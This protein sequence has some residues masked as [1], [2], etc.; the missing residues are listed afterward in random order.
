MDNVLNIITIN[1]KDIKQYEQNSKQHP[2]WHIDQIKKSIQEFG[3]NDLIAITDNFEIIEGHGRFEAIKRLGY[4]KI[5]CFV[6]N[7][8]DD[9]SLKKY[10][11]IHN[12]LTLNTDFDFNILESELNKLSDFNIESYGFIF[13]N[14]DF[15]S[16]YLDIDD[17]K[18]DNITKLDK[19]IC[20]NCKYIADKSAFIVELE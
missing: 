10:R 2:R 20:P 9:N 1:I 13:S 17:I 19:L 4:T 5:K 16:D 6:I 15:H 3:Y 8:L 18:E 12:Q 7:N 11:L 14:T